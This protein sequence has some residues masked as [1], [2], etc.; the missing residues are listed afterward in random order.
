MLAELL[1][2]YKERVR[3]QLLPLVAVLA[4]ACGSDP[5]AS[6]DDGA[7][8][9]PMPAGEGSETPGTSDDAQDEPR[10]L[11]TMDGSFEFIPWDELVNTGLV[12][13]TTPGSACVFRATESHAASCRYRS[14]SDLAGLL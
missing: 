5:E 7:Q 10:P 11:P 8:G 12:T 1:V 4:L 13:P 3:L 9:V 14:K 6:P 2:G